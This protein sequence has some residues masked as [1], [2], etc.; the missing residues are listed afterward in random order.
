MMS[1]KAVVG[2]LLFLFAFIFVFNFL[3]IS[4]F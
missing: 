1:L 3:L 4:T 2:R